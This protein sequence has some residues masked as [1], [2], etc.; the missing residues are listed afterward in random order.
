M[1]GDYIKEDCIKEQHLSPEDFVR[2]LDCDDTS[3][4]Y[5]NW[6]DNISEHLENCEACKRIMRRMV[7]AEAVCEED[8]L[9]GGMALLAQEAE[10]R[11]KLAESKEMAGGVKRM[12]RPGR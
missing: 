5:L 6:Y 8:L 10:I 11:S 9:P 3:D 7:H 4:E 12:Q 2:C 1:Q